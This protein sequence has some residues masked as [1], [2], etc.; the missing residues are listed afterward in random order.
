LVQ[1]IGFDGSGTHSDNSNLSQ[2]IFNKAVKIREKQV[3]DLHLYSI[4]LNY[5]TEYKNT[6]VNFNI[7]TEKNKN[8]VLKQVLRALTPPILYNGLASTI[9]K[10]R[11][12]AVTTTKK[13]TTQS[14]EDK[15]KIRERVLNSQS[16]NLNIY[17]D[18][19]MAQILETWGEDHVWNEIQLLLCNQKGKVLDVAC[20]TG[21]V[22]QLLQKFP[23]LDVFG[24]DISDLLIE[25]AL[26]KNIPKEKLIVCDATNMSHY[27]DDFFDYSYSIGSLEHF[28]EQ[29]IV[30][31]IRENYR[32]VKNASFHQI[33]VSLSNKDEGW[34]TPYQSYFNNSIEWWLEKFYTSY[35]DVKTIKS[36]WKDNRSIGMWFIC[37]KKT[38][39]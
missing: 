18:K 28:T 36:G 35:K 34:I 33:P 5:F 11:S 31:F 37:T 2:E 7:H 26:S 1:N 22:I 3:V 8:M 25:K 16:Q 12:R 23:Q 15:P 39:L 30:D 14:P 20:G 10:L 32:I 4:L 27:E 24:C 19:Q 17:W 29:G 21:T 6:G 9:M 38:E 13:D